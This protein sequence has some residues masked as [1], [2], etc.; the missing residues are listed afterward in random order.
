MNGV[1]RFLGGGSATPSSQ[2]APL[3]SVSNGV[4]ESSPPKTTAAL[5]F[6]K[7]RS[8]ATPPSRQ[9]DDD[10]HSSFQ[11]SRNSLESGRT[12]TQ[13]SSPIAGPSSPRAPVPIRV[14]E[15]ARN[16][17]ATS[18]RTSATYSSKDDLLITLL[19]SE[20]LVDSRD[21]DILSAEEVEDLKKESQTLTTRLVAL[22]KKLTLETKLRDAALSLSKA[23]SSYKGGS[24][25]TSEQVENASRKV[26]AAQKEVWRISE[27]AVEVNRRLLEHRAG[28]LSYS[29]RSVEKKMAGPDTNGDP[30]ASGGSTPNRNSAMS[31]TQSSVLSAQSNASRSK[32]DGAH[33]FAGHSDAIVPFG[34][35]RGL[36]ASSA[37]LTALQEQLKTAQDALEVAN[38]Q[39]QKMS[40]E[41]T[42]L[43]S[44]KSSLASSKDSELR[45]S[46][47]MIAA[48]ERQMGDMQ[49][50]GDRVRS[51]EN[52]KMSWQN[53]KA[54]LD[55]KRSEV[56]RLQQ[57]M[58]LLERQG[59]E[60]TTVQS[61]LARE[62]RKLD[63]KDREIAELKAERV[64][65]LA[66]GANKQELHDGVDALQGVMMKYSVSHYSRDSS[67]IALAASIDQHLEEVQA[68]LDAQGRTQE[69]WNAARSKLEV[70]LRASLDKREALDEQLEAARK[71]RDSAKADNHILEGK[72]RE[73]QDG[74]APTVEYTGEAA[75]ITELLQPVWSILPSPEAR[76]QKM[77]K[78]KAVL[79]SPTVGTSPVNKGTA[80]LSEMDVRSLKT[81][82]DPNALS[83]A[84]PG[85][86]D[87]F[88]VEA[89]VAR[90]QALINDDRALIERL[91]RF[92]QA[93]D[94]LKKN[95]ERA[96]KLAQESNTALETYQ[97]Q[98][99]LLEERNVSM[100][101]K[102][103]TF[104]DEIANLQ[105][106]VDRLTAEK[107][108]LETLA[109]EQA[110]TCSQLTEANNTLSARV[111]NLAEQSNG[112]ATSDTERRKL[113][114]KLEAERK[115]LREDMGRLEVEKL[116][117]EA[118]K[119]RLEEELQNNQAALE[120]A[121]EDVEAMRM[122]QQTQQMALLDE[123]NTV[124]TE[125]ATLRAQLRK[126]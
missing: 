39:Q 61:D 111:L 102:Q 92:A 77:G 88:S 104:T 99:K 66:D 21:F 14:A 65:L 20:A 119:A 101:S 24:Q 29:L 114:Q 35:S 90:V 45:Q 37:A 81:L 122:S 4:D 84:R 123:L 59:G 31:P 49:G 50:F 117:L 113:E 36:G 3:P 25:Q 118:E 41:L 27:Q 96:Q 32:F 78:H 63:E 95:A 124:Q 47:E 76:V 5:V 125:N 60:I 75:K 109:A 51:L 69:E 15:L 57:Q 10:G 72:V 22:S 13:P 55:E 17:S 44:E 40:R 19:A 16:G 67:V 91:I 121:T 43:R 64:A 98:V 70:D 94:L 89:F 120:R 87:V 112:A 56:E 68:K 33:F 34:A 23:T 6:R 2:T 73:Y 58:S 11:S 28:V 106:A 12:S 38:A 79:P 97:K 83:S 54:E 1:R 71:E 107:L 62:R 53:D 110:E 9:S 116:S 86:P 100:I 126:K 48:L 30:S 26:D 93:H 52:E 74:H 105:E 7:D 103:A 108:D 46:E 115:R 82:Y 85:G 42:S 18:K 80:S 8:R